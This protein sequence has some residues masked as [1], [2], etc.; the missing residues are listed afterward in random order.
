MAM[1]DGEGFAVFSLDEAAVPI[2][3]IVFGLPVGIGSLLGVAFAADATAGGD[4]DVSWGFWER[5]S[6][7]GHE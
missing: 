5:M 2:G 3:G 7:N 1:M 6:T 4:L